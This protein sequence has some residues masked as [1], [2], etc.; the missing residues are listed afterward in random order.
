M[1]HELY[2]S[3][4]E[5]LAPETLSELAGQS[6]SRVHCVPFERSGAPGSQLLAVEADEGLGPRYVLKCAS[7]EWD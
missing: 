6:I 2:D 1:Q 3:I 4:E 5:M 7:L